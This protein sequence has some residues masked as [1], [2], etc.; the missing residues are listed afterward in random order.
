[1]AFETSKSFRFDLKAVLV[2]F[3][4]FLAQILLINKKVKKNV[5]FNNKKNKEEN[6]I[7]NKNCGPVAIKTKRIRRLSQ[8]FLAF[9]FLFGLAAA[10]TAGAGKKATPRSSSKTSEKTRRQAVG[11]QPTRKL[12]ITEKDQLDEIVKM[13]DFRLDPSHK[14]FDQAFRELEKA[15]GANLKFFLQE[16]SYVAS[17]GEFRFAENGRA[18]LY[19]DVIK[20]IFMSEMKNYNAGFR[21]RDF[22]V[23]K[24]R[25][26]EDSIIRL[27]EVVVSVENHISKIPTLSGLF[28]QARLIEAKSISEFFNALSLE[29]QRSP[30]GKILFI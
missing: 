23:M 27:L 19:R 30:E 9:I 4:F 14:A 10:L 17:K 22:G 5:K 6:M 28:S 18:L 25:E 21:P 24:Q 11:Q 13:V 26:R 1:M 3:F 16:V 20:S 8:G 29:M 12:Q 2:G 7:Y 15:H